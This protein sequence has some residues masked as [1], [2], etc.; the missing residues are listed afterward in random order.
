[1]DTVVCHCNGWLW[2]VTGVSWWCVTR[3]TLLSKQLPLKMF[4]KVSHWCGL[5]PLASVILSEWGPRLDSSQ[6]SYCFPVS[7]SSCHFG[8]TGLA[9]SYAAEVHGWVD[10][11]V[12]QLKALDLDLGGSWLSWSTCP[13]SHNAP[14]GP[15]LPLCPDEGRHQFCPSDFRVLTK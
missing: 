5:R 7:R 12:D 15:A 1:M 9:P 2:C 10:V 8:S 11:G 6:I 4:T 14:P 13:L 3:S